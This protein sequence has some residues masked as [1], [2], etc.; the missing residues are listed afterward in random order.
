MAGKDETSDSSLEALSDIAASGSDGEP[1]IQDLLAVTSEF[2]WQ[3]GDILPWNSAHPGAVMM[4]SA[5]PGDTAQAITTQS[6]EVLDA[7]ISGLRQFVESSDE[8]PEM[9]DVLGQL[10]ASYGCRYGV[11]GDVEDLEE[12]ILCGQQA[13]S[14]IYEDDSELAF[15]LLNLGTLLGQRYDVTRMT[16]DLDEV[17]SYTRRAIST[18]TEVPGEEVH[19]S[20]LGF[21]LVRRFE[22]TQS[23]PDLDN[24][25]SALRSAIPALPDS[26]PG[27]YETSRDHLLRLAKAKL[28]RDDDLGY[29]EAILQE[30]ATQDPDAAAWLEEWKRRS[31][32]LD[33][34]S[35][36]QLNPE[37]EEI[38]GQETDDDS[39]GQASEEY[40]GGSVDSDWHRALLQLTSGEGQEV[41]AGARGGL[42]TQSSEES[43]FIETRGERLIENRV[44]FQQFLQ[45]MI[46]HR[47]N[48]IVESYPIGSP[49]DLKRHIDRTERVYQ[50]EN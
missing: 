43:W 27:I 13:A 47:D 35:L 14:Y 40:A 21:L 39:D 4:S 16:E 19:K 9:I 17:I 46:L 22:A 5:D 36:L 20:N 3:S 6:L 49:E 38:S 8:T 1:T 50:E 45:L 26:Q 28:Y 29:F 23:Q 48:V 24:A 34:R 2:L 11:S 31:E 37:M 42:E 7:L 33:L 32:T 18:L 10:L 15:I 25:I 41:V 30:L 12:G 44:H